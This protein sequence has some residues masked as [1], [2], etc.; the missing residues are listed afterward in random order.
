MSGRPLGGNRSTAI[1]S[2]FLSRIRTI[3][4]H[5]PND[6]FRHLAANKAHWRIA[7]ASR[8]PEAGW[9]EPRQVGATAYGGRAKNARL[10]SY[11]DFEAPC[12]PSGAW[13]YVAEFRVAR[14]KKRFAASRQ[15]GSQVSARRASFSCRSF[16]GRCFLEVFHAIQPTPNLNGMKVEYCFKTGFDFL[17]RREAFAPATRSGSRC[18]PEALQGCGRAFRGG[19]ATGTRRAEGSGSPDAARGLRAVCRQPGKLFG[20]GREETG[21]AEDAAEERKGAAREPL[22]VEQGQ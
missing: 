19:G 20:Q 14:L 7:N 22:K 17:K 2:V 9:Y 8:V 6:V 1:P 13:A 4:R 18:W 15:A 16:G 11:R 21:V 12:F 3:K 5:P 10:I